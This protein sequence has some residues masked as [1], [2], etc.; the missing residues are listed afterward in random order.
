[1]EQKAPNNKSEKV[2]WRPAILLFFQMSS[3]IAIPVIVG[4]FIGKWLDNRYGTEPWL[5]LGI[6]GVAFI[7][8]IVGMVRESSRV[9]RSLDSSEDSK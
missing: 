8:S 7:I 4:L 5:F 1:M 9:M 3:W 2:W 6:T